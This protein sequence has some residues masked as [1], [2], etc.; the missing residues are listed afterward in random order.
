MFSNEIRSETVIEGTAAE[1][2]EVLA[3]F[4]R[5]REWN[6]G[7]EK[8]EGRAAVGETLHLTF[9]KEGGRGMKMHPTVLVAEPGRELRWLGRL[10]LPGIFD[11]E[12]RFEIQEIEP[13]R[14]RFVQSER[15]SGLLVPFLRKTIE[16]DTLG[17]FQKV[18]AALAAR[19]VERGAAA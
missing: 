4:A 19:V 14:V 11:G 2:W 17:T 6:P 5:Y 3:D 7:F 18:N 9:A 12:H 15:F 16:V 13:G 1:V 8:A 10:W